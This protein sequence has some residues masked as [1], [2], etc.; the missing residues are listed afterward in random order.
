[1]KKR[2][3]PSEPRKK[4][5]KKKAATKA[6]KSVKVVR[7]PSVSREV[8]GVTKLLKDILMDGEYEV[9]KKTWTKAFEDA[10]S[11]IDSVALLS[12]RAE[13]ELAQGNHDDLRAVANRMINEHRSS[14]GRFYLAQSHYIRGQYDH[15]TKELS[16][17]LFGSPGNPNAIFL[18]AEIADRTGQK[19]MGWKALE[20]ITKSSKRPKIWHLMSS[21]V[22]N[23]TDVMRMLQAWQRWK[24]S[25]LGAAFNHD[26]QEFLALGAMRGGNYDLARAIWRQTLTSALKV[27]KGIGS[28]KTR[29]PSYSS[30]RAETALADVNRV[31]RDAGIE[32]FLV[33][34]TLLGCVRENRLLGHDKDIDVGIW[35]DVKL[36]AF[37]NAATQS[38][39]FFTLMSRS[40]EIIRLRHVNGIAIDVFYHYRDP[41]D[42][43]HGGVKMVWHNKP[44]QLV[45]REFLG[46]S[47]LIPEDYDLYLTENYGDWRVPKIDFDSAFDTPNGE[48]RDNDE[49]A[50]HSFKGLLGACIEHNWRKAGFY[51]TQLEKFG[52]G[53]F[54]DKYAGYLIKKFKI[55]DD[56]LFPVPPAPA[57]ESPPAEEDQ[58]EAA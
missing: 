31:C 5:T 52:E 10:R 54:K 57:K 44:F 20:E 50:I 6:K 9:V 34:G 1:M 41:E 38:G 11:P 43:W 4:V 19:E 30:R 8:A 2:S 56:T 28:L 48:V 47:Y 35:E 16:T 7:K 27:K 42:Y 55:S 24:K 37:M 3:E 40:N 18:L 26:A 29:T 12:L 21:L 39:L 45:P 17:L 23:D 25:K 58:A 53:A 33:S 46:E 22:E 13:Y 32:M 36:D 51:L 49:M 15:A 14:L